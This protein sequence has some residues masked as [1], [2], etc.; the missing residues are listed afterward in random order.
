MLKQ[1]LPIAAI[2]AI[3]FSASAEK[4]VLFEGEEVMD[5]YPGL[6]IAKS[7]I[8][9]AEAGATLAID[10]DFTGDGYS[11]KLGINWTNDVLPSFTE[12]SGYS[13]Q[14]HTV[15]TS[16]KTI[17][18]VVTAEDIAAL[19][20]DGDSNLHICG[21]G[22][23]ITKVTIE[24]AAQEGDFETVDLTLTNE[25]HNLLLSEYENYDDEY[26]MDLFLNISNEGQ[27]TQAGWGVGQILRISD[28][29]AVVYNISAK[30]VS[31]E[32][33]VNKYKFKVGDFKGF[34]K[35]DDG[36]YWVDEYGQSG[37]T[38]NLWGGAS[39]VG[40]QVQVPSSSA[41]NSIVVDS[42]NAPV[43]YYN[44]QGVRVVNPQNGLYI[45]RQGNKATKVLVK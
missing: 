34:A 31:A 10:V 11:W 30:E 45:K 9:D 43:E 18:Y 2:A 38:F 22:G 25:N 39:M 36:T 44:L 20:A 16:S 28:Y 19:E 8:I 40:V 4:T 12:V 27:S 6:E 37:V 3:S 23:T 15:W 29:N 21:S 14:W 33:V 1:L 7:K 26:E 32:G 35:L 41:V 5:W 13:E 24:P 17:E 42:E